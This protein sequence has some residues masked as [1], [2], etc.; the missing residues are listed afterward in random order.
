M[1]LSD[2]SLFKEE[3]DLSAGASASRAP[4]SPGLTL[5]DVTLL[6]VPLSWQEAVAVM[7]EALDGLPANSACPDPG[8]ITLSPIGE[9][10]LLA[11][12]TLSGPGVRR[13]AAF[14]KELLGSAIAPAELRALIGRDS[15]E[16][17]EHTSIAEFTRALTYFERPNR[18]ADV[19]AVYARAHAVYVDSV[20]SQELDRLRAKTAAQAESATQPRTSLRDRL[21]P[22]VLQAALVVS[23]C[24]VTTVSAITL[25]T[26][27]FAP[28]QE[29]SAGAAGP[30]TPDLSPTA[31]LQNAR[32]EVGDLLAGIGIPTTRK[33]P[34]PA[35]SSSSSAKAVAPSRGRPPAG[36]IAAGERLGEPNGGRAG[37]TVSTPRVPL[38]PTEFMTVPVRVV[39]E[40]AAL[41]DLTSETDAAASV[42]LFDESQPI[43]SYSDANVAPPSLVRPQLPSSQ[44]DE[45][46][47]DLLSEFELL[48][49]RTGR[50]EQVKLIS[51][52]NRLN[53]RMLMAAAKAWLFQPAMKEGQPV[54]YRYSIRIVP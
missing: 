12:G 24:I 9:T 48:I 4:D 34:A 28:A 46:S 20:A 22:R 18:R 44:S 31:A 52:G 42:S 26:Y 43:F 13:A 1:D 3:A 35:A 32:T 47:L 6:K 45:T 10:R 38:T 14:L 49:G 27:A 16:Q 25:F 23:L 50:V 17:P 8:R 7:L 54:R 41:A 33:T 39:K 53:D 11:G 5:Q 40:S 21:S 51:P 2:L 30:Q 37:N 15:S 36:R 19:A 29:A